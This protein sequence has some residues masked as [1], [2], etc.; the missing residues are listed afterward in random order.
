MNRAQRRQ[1][2]KMKLTPKDIKQIEDNKMAESIQFAVNNYSIAMLYCLHEELGFGK[3]RGPKFVEKVQTVFD[4]LSNGL[5]NFDD[6]VGVVR[7]EMGIN[8]N[9]KVIE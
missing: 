4:D 6:L 9:R 8:F 5:I 1:V 7:E 3:K 2:A